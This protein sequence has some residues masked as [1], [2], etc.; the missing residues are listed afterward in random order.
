MQVSV[1]KKKAMRWPK[2]KRKAMQVAIKPMQQ[3]WK[4]HFTNQELKFLPSPCYFISCTER[5]Y[6]TLQLGNLSKNGN[7]TQLKNYLP[8]EF[9]S[10][11]QITPYQTRPIRKLLE[12]HRTF[13]GMGMLMPALFKSALEASLAREIISSCRNIMCKMYQK[14]VH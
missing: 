11:T 13:I 14:F 7:Q 10:P 6:F 12:N 2:K 8:Q 4:S 5:K 3:G 1:Q 9:I